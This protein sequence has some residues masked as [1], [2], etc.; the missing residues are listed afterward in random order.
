M[1]TLKNLFLFAIFGLMANNAFAQGTVKGTVVEAGTNEP[2]PGA[3]VVVVGTTKGV[4]TDFDGNFVLEV[5]AGE[6]TLKFSFVGY[7]ANTVKVNVENGK[8]IDLGK[9]TLK[10]SAASLDEVVIVG[11]GVI[12]LAKDRKTPIAVSTIKAKEIQEKIGNFDLPELLTS[13]PSVQSIKGGGYGGGKMYLRGF[14]Q[15]NTAFLLNGQPINGME[16]GKMYWSNWSG[17][18]DIANAVQVQRGLGSSKLAIS[19][20]GGTVNIVTK[21]VDKKEGGFVSAMVANDNYLKGTAYYSTGIMSNGLAVAAMFGHWQGDGYR[22]GTPGQ[23]QTY[24]LSFGYKPNERNIFNFL[25]TGAPQW[26]GDAWNVALNKYLNNKEGGKFNPYYGYKKGELYPGLRNFYHKPIINLSWDFNINDSSKLS[27]VLYGSIGRGGYAYMEGAAWGLVDGEK[28][29]GMDFDSLIALNESQS[30][31]NAAGFQKG[32]YNGHNWYGLV[33]NYENKL[34]ENVTFNVGG[35]VRMY[36]GIHFRGVVDFMGADHYDTSSTYSGNYSINNNY[37]A[38]DPW[39]AITN[40]NDDH[41]QRYKYDYEEF[42]TYYGVF[43][44][45]EYSKDKFATFFQGAVS[46]QEHQVTN[47]YNYD[48]AKKSEKISNLGY[49]IKGGASYKINDN[50][51]TYFNAGYYS[52]QPFHD[53]IFDNLR[54]SVDVNEL[55]NKNET[56]IGLELGHNYKTQKFNLSLDLYYTKWLDRTKTYSLVDDNDPNIVYDFQQ[57]GINEIHKGIEIDYNYKPYNNIKL[58]GFVSLGDWKY[59]KEPTTRV[60]DED[61]N[62]ITSTYTGPIRGSYEEGDV[63]GGAAQF[64]A[65]FGL[66]YE[67]VKN[68]KINGIQK[69]YD[70]LYSLGGVPLP[71]YSV[72][73]AGLSY[74]MNIKKNSLTFRLN[75]N[76]VFDK[77]YIE[78]S[79]DGQ[80]V[81]DT[82]TDVWKGVDTRNQVSIGFGRTWNF[83]VKYAF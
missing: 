70:R 59:G 12:D 36:N 22:N 53:N 75:V 14:D 80:F 72:V 83:G 61:G 48:T 4:A 9:V 11:T 8:T 66:D 44:Q 50:N 74:K 47:Y 32:S 13:T 54:K 67:I 58:Y 41:K 76:N 63:I 65:A 38:W 45:V 29:G 78:Y 24:F 56:V 43:G 21:T 40:F 39:K 1:R 5:P 51:N 57:N 16:D 30:N 73:D 64:T 82:T 42:I 69:Y 68:L 35:D 34:N 71:S 15:T 26:H 81:D 37:G 17:V 28:D 7:D 46:N 3:D 77:F 49:N 55:A 6:Q 20:V 62:E 23:G 10:A 60:F 27:T 25:V 33:T 19:S 52:R 31:G 79:N 2:L 18:L